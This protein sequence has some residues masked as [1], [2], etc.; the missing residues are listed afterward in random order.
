VTAV[1]ASADPPEIT[2][3]P[4]YGIEVQWPNDDPDP[5]WSAERCDFPVHY[6]DS[7]KG[8]AIAFGTRFFMVAPG[9]RATITNMDTGGVVRLPV[10]GS[11][12]VTEASADGN[13]VVTET[14]HG[15]GIDITPGQLT[16]FSGTRVVVTEYDESNLVVA[17]PT[18]TQ[19]G[20]TV[21]VC[22]VLDR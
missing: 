11:V 6:Q 10:N 7:G 15:P 5:F 21:D 9:L 2:R 12:T 22:A 19:R 20:R 17:G 16:W 1:P 14:F 8:I 13:T 4:D 3:Y 18:M